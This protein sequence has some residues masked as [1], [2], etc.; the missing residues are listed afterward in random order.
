[1]DMGFEKDVTVI[2][3]RLNSAGSSRQNVLLSATLTH[4]KQTSFIKLV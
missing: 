4:G 3:N 2:V 1:M